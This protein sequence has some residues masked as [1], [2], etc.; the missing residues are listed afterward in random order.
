MTNTKML[1]GK[2]KEKC[3]TINSLAN[4]IGIS[5]TGLFNKIHN[6]REFTVNE[7]LAVSDCLSLSFSER[8]QIFFADL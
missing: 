4:R 3:F 1:Q 6:D 8:D 2:M 7:M 5:K